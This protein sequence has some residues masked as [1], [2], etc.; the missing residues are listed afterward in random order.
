MRILMLLL[1]ARFA[2][3]GAA[4]W[5]DRVVVFDIPLPYNV[6]IYNVNTTRDERVP[7]FVARRSDAG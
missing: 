3:P 4:R 7:S 5:R 2:P 6:C 1:L